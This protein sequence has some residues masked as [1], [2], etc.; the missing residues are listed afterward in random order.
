MKPEG[1]GRPPERK[2]D[3]GIK[4]PGNIL[5]VPGYIGRVIAGFFK[6]LVS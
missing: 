6:I 1:F 5:E 2:K 3:N 4:K